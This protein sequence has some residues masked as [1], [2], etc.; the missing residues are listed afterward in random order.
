[1][2]GVKMIIELINKQ[3][4]D[5]QEVKERSGFY[6]SEAGKCSRAI[7][8][9]FI[10]APKEDFSIETL[11]KFLT[12]NVIH[13]K[14]QKILKDTGI[15]ISEEQATP[16]NEFNIHGRCDAII[17]LNNQKQVLEIKSIASYG[18]R[19]LKEAKDDHIL[20]L[21]VYLHFFKI[22]S[23]YLLYENKDSSDLKVFEIKYD[24]NLAKK[25]IKKFSNI[26]TALEKK[27]VPEREFEKSAWQCRYC[28]FQKHC[29]K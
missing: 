22:K 9:D 15:L 23:G 5:N 8:Y 28:N 2:M 27:E 7:Y 12:G 25:V 6:A 18:Y 24:F 13:E 19:Q 26:Q 14:L 20:Q 16:Q 1:M 4:I 21:Q 3:I 17:K 29:W 11:R 10:K